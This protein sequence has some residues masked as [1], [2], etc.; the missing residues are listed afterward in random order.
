[1]LNQE[2]SL[3]TRFLTENSLKNASRLKI[4]ERPLLKVLATQVFKY[5]SSLGSLLLNVTSNY[6]EL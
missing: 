5:K 6:D 2:S 3:N 1:M 4:F